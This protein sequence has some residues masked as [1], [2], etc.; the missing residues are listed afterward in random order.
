MKPTITTLMK[1]IKDS[2][3]IDTSVFEPVDKNNVRLLKQELDKCRKESEIL[4]TNICNGS[5]DPTESNTV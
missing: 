4:M 3:S 1:T 2:G 5:L